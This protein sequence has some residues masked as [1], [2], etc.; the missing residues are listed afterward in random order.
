G[1]LATGVG[2]AVDVA[3]AALPG[4]T[5]P[6]DLPASRRWFERDL[7]EPW[8]LLPDGT[9]PVRPRGPVHLPD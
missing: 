8:E 3:L 2:K 6:G 1:M 4:I 5:L 7:T 9:L